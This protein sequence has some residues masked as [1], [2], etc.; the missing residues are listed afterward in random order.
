M[1]SAADASEEHLL[2]ERLL[3]MSRAYLLSRAIHVA[4]ELGV[5][6]HVGDTAVRASELARLTGSY[7]PYLERLLR[8]LA[9]YGIFAEAA[10]G[11]FLATPLSALLADGHPTSMRAGLSMVNSA[12]WAAVGDLDHAVRTGNTA[13]DFRHR[14]PFFAYL[15]EN[16]QEQQSFDAGM[17]SNSRS[18][19]QAIARAYD[20]SRSGLLLDIGG[21]RGGL[22]KAVLERHANLRGQLFDQPQVIERAQAI[23][24]STALQGRLSYIAGDFFQA[25]PGGADTYLLKGVLHDFDDERCMQ[26]LKNCR[27][28]MQ[29]PSKLL[30]IE[31]LVS[32][33]NLAHQAKTIDVLMMVLLGGRERPASAWADLLRGADFQLRQQLSTDSEFTISE[34]TPI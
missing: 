19:D 33:D 2:R 6:N 7:E 34:A 20:F 27:R 21:G 32:P 26:I 10:P 11:S 18:S 3:E 16:P 31:R 8:F 9:G 17:A 23:E 12:W 22:L 15:K 25:V 28:A 30:I 29:P 24:A 13:F 1:S 5:A 14:Q 4:A